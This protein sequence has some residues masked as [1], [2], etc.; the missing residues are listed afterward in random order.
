MIHEQLS[1]RLSWVDAWQEAVGVQKMGG[2][3]KEEKYQIYIFTCMFI[4]QVEVAMC[5]YI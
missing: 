3:S 4:G 1:W 2:V 5:I